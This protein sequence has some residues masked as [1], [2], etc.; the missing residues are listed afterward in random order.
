MLA[1]TTP[2]TSLNEVTFNNGHYSVKA[3]GLAVKRAYKT[4]QSMVY[5]ISFAGSNTAC[6]SIRASLHK[7]K[8]KAPSSRWVYQN[9][10]AAPSMKTEKIKLPNSTELHYIMWDAAAPLI[11]I[12]DDRA[13]ALRQQTM[14]I[15]GHEGRERALEALKNEYRTEIHRRFAEVINKH[16]KAPMLPEWAEIIMDDTFS[17]T[18]A[19]WEELDVYGDVV[20]AAIIKPDY[21]WTDKISLMLKSGSIKIP[22]LEGDLATLDKQP[23]RPA[24]ITNP[25]TGE[26]AL[27]IS[28]KPNPSYLFE[29][30]RIFITSNFADVV[31]PDFDY[32]TYIQ[33]HLTGDW[34]EPEMYPEDIEENR[35]AAATTG[36]NRERVF[37]VFIHS[38]P[39]GNPLK[40]WVITE[41]D[42]SA[43]T[44]LLPE[45]Y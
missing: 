34:R 20:Y 25:D 31:G 3:L 19:A 23:E 40:F 9:L 28:V 22:P 12:R 32:Q 42:R 37:S 15:S 16:T 45:D 29:P 5:Y 27:E 36:N 2:D 18:G 24:L 14:P 10:P 43:T 4:A 11:L 26:H 35:R 17:Y 41:W 39:D 21:K 8:G 6:E 30:G 13:L 7:R 44:F 38:R 1:T 33:R